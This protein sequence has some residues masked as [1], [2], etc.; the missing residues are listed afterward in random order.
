M[1]MDPQLRPLQPGRPQRRHRAGQRRR[2]APHRL[3]RRLRPRGRD[4]PRGRHQ[5]QPADSQVPQRGAGVVTDERRHAEVLVVDDERAGAGGPRLPAAPASPDRLGGDRL[6][7]HRGAAAAAGRELRGGVPR[8]PHARPRRAGA[9]PGAVPL[10]PPAGDHLR[11][12]LR[13][14]RRRGLRAAGRRLPPEAR[15]ARAPVRRHPPPRRPAPAGRRRRR[16][17]EDDLDRIAVETGGRT[18]MVERDS[19]RFV[20]ASGDYVRL[21]TDDGAFLVRMPISSL[22]DAVARRR[23]RPGPPPLPDRPPPCHRAADPAR[24]RLRPRGRRPGAAGQPAPRPGAARPA[25]RSGAN[26]GPRG[27]AQ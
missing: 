8:H 6:R 4:R 23:V 14:A 3:R 2:A 22:E 27:R 16:A 5:G 15:P 18:R 9:G 21:H 7:R 13:A 19:I 10:R 24:R 26:R 1:G 12:R 17:G 25:V 11:H 20:E